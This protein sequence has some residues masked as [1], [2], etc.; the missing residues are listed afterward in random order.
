V[1][2]WLAIL[3]TLAACHDPEVE[4]LTAIQAEVCACAT[5]SCAEQAMKRVPQGTIKS[6]HRT[7]AI[8]RDMLDC[9]AKLH[10]AEQP[11]TDPDAED[12]SAEPPAA[13]PPG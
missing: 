7:Q 9:L 4:R 11:T 12:S 8:A 2:S 5:A 10:E 13:A 3:V 1:R 6:T